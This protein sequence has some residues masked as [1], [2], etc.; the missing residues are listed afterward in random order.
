MKR[1]ALWSAAGSLS[2]PFGPV[3]VA[4]C[5]IPHPVKNNKANA[6]ALPFLLFYVHVLFDLCYHVGSTMCRKQKGNLVQ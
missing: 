6:V 2:L 5:P 4:A 1:P 3:P